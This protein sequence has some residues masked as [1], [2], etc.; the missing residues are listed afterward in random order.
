VK[1]RRVARSPN[2]AASISACPGFKWSSAAAH[3]RTGQ[4]IRDATPSKVSRRLDHV[5]RPWKAV[6]PELFAQAADVGVQDQLRVARRERWP[7]TALIEHL[8]ATPIP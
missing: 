6:E 3:T 1:V 5:T 2:A 7:V 8:G 4:A